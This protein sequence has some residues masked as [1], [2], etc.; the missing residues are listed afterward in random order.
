M[1][2]A[3]PA[4]VAAPAAAA[5]SKKQK[6]LVVV[7]ALFVLILAGGAAFVAFGDFGKGQKSSTADSS[8]GTTSA[9]SVLPPPKLCPGTF[10]ETVPPELV[11]FTAM[12]MTTQPGAAIPSLFSAEGRLNEVAAPFFWAPYNTA[13]TTDISAIRENYAK[14]LVLYNELRTKLQ[15][16][17]ALGANV[18]I[19]VPISVAGDSAANDVLA[20]KIHSNGHYTVKGTDMMSMYE[21]SSCIHLRDKGRSGGYTCIY[22]YPNADPPRVIAMAG[23]A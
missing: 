16:F 6:L 14:A 11:E 12:M 7:G 23:I 5:E 20:N 19:D 1:S 21:N 17:S 15:H 13:L 3:P 18:T 10:V 22:S 4:P 9:P 2:A 8:G